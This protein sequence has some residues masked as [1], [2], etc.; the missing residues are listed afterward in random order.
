MTSPV[1]SS[2]S[3]L[4]EFSNNANKGIILPWTNGDVGNPVNGTIIFNTV[5]KKV[6]A[7]LNNAWVDY[8][9]EASTN[10]SVDTSLQNSAAFPE[11]PNAGVVIGNS[12]TVKGILVLESQD[13]AL[14]LPKVASPHLNIIN[15][16]PGM[17]VFDT[18]KELL[19]I[20]NGT[21]WSFIQK[22]L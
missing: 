7:F 4:L 6:K 1:V 13:K 11:N 18:V 16:S 15:P 21:Q 9:N 10:N 8:S 17:I 5:S 12:S 22:D 19:C 20:Y 3:V 14:V 2:T